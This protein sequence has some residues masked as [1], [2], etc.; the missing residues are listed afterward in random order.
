MC[1]GIPMQVVEIDAASG[2]AFAWCE[3]QLGGET[4]RERL[5]VLWLGDV[6]P[7]DWVYAVLGQARER[8]SAERAGEIRCALEGVQA[9][10]AGETCLDG[11]FADLARNVPK[12]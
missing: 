9:A 2:G 11:F 7:G 10:L 12:A 6:A 5:N 1:L 3:G 8:L 4:R